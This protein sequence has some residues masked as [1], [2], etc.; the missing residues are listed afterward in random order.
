M[1]TVH[2]KAFHA[3]IPILVIILMVWQSC[4]STYSHTKTKVNSGSITVTPKIVFLNYSIKQDKSNGAIELLLINKK[5]TEGNLKASNS[6]TGLSKP[7]DLKCVTLDNHMNPV[8]SIIVPD[9]LNVTIES[10]NET[11]ALLIKEISK[12]SAQF[13]IRL[14]LSERI[15]AIGIKKSTNFGSQNPYLLITKLK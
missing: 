5:I 2:P 1:G 4:S 7:G 6:R 9:P 10:V 11:N 13:S 14:Q 15:Y 8:D 12:D 3:V